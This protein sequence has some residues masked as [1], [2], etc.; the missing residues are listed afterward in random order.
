MHILASL[1]MKNRALVA[2]VTA[3]IAFFGV[4]S[5]TGLK[6]ELIPSISFPQLVV[7][8]SYPGASPDVVNDDVSTPIE[9][10]IQGVEGLD[11]TT[12]TSSTNSST[13]SATFKYGTDLGSAEQKVSQAIN[14]IKSTLPDGSDPQ[15][16]SGSIDDLPVLQ[17][18]VT[19]DDDQKA[20]AAAVDA[21][22]VPELEKIDGVR[23]ATVDGAVG[24]RVSIT[25]D[26]A[27]LATA[28]LSSSDIKT[29]L[30]QNGTLIP[31]G[32][33]TQD[34]STLS[35]QAGAKL[36]STGDIKALPL[37]GSAGSSASGSASEGAAAAAAAATAAGGT[38]A[39]VTTIGDVATVEL[40]DDPATSVSLVNGKPALTIAITKTPDGNTVAISKA[41]NDKLPDL[42]DRLGDGAKFTT[43]FDQA[44]FIQQSI[45]SLA[46]EGGLGLIFAIIVILL[47]LFSIR[48]TIVTAISIP[49]SLLIT[50]IGLQASGYTLN[51]LT[52]GA[53]TIAIGRVVDDSIVVIENIKRHLD[54]GEERAGT[55]VRAVREVAGAIT[56][57]TITTVAV[58]LPISFVGGSVG[59][60]FRPFALTVA[61][62]LLASLFVALTI[63]PV[64]AYWFLRPS[65][66]AKARLAALEA[67]QPHGNHAAAVAADAPP[68]VEHSAEHAHA[69]KSLEDDEEPTRLQRAYRPIIAWTLK[70]SVATVLLAV[71]VLVGTGALFPFMKTNFLGDSGQNSLSVTQTVPVGESLDRQRDTAL[72]A[73]SALQDVS[74]VDTV[75]V[76]V[77]SGGGLA[78]S[79]GGG[80]SNSI[81]YSITTDEDADQ[82]KVQD[83]VRD[84]FD[85][86][87]KADDVSVGAGG[88]LGGSS[89]IDV[90]ITASK[91]A[92][93]QSAD[94][95]LSAALRK[96]PEADQVESNLSA[97][98]PYVAV[99]VDRTKA[100]EAGLSE[101]AVGGL[102][103]QA[104]QPSQVGSIVI[105][106]TSLSV[107]LDTADAPTTTGELEKLQIPTASGA[108][109][110]STLAKVERVNGPAS[111]TTE[112]GLRTATVSVTPK[113]D[114][115]ASA[116]A[117]VQTAID[118]ADL[119]SG[120]TATVGGATA[121]QNDAF[122]QLGIALLVAI[123]IVYI[124][125]VATFRSL[126][127]PLLLLVSVPFAAT[128]AILL[129]VVTGV[130]LG[131]ASLIGVLML[132]GIVVTNAI[133]LVDL[134]NQYR[135]RGM[136]VRD[137]L[138]HGATRR[139][140]PILMTALAT[141]FALIPM[142]LGI[143]G[144]GG[145]ISQPLAIVVI[146]GLV[147]S[148]VLTLVVLPVIYNLVEGRRERRA[149]RKN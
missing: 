1:S 73:S 111:I 21:N 37:I 6:Q 139:L 94:D 69:A 83:D 81:S 61:I 144:H 34:G 75:Q 38:P 128:G 43:V 116:S 126:L 145:F 123:L 118:D 72:Q 52:L 88:G 86:I 102:V 24:Q 31:G 80:S 71:L 60:L 82:A 114:D 54:H 29:A 108:V 35:V 76:T 70:H 124:V 25:P 44:P 112:R 109:D 148:T 92:Q 146:G 30:E 133:V 127:Q 36:T 10:A 66:R 100:A 42:Q 58:F 17:L 97:S 105:D 23:D 137:A 122:G 56:A 95:D 132:I 49:A 48:S 26:V 57:S 53:L 149:A 51:I 90:E 2:L 19:G 131:V 117:A 101:A 140:R 27:K 41:V 142:A 110:L 129:Q 74:G 99:Q 91:Q 130:P 62:A 65:K 22:V 46:E 47:F 115:L 107:Y 18:A 68:A 103:S 135:S 28:G 64:L 104:I 77:G 15:V 59:E 12:A 8:T 125:M 55:I 136:S 106:D 85:G 89:T 16:V 13:V 50:F 20:L 96:L 119:P 98:L 45:S 79:F 9:S 33:I 143:T 84:A 14:R 67:E 40:T 7:V 138:M 121:D 32:D 11:T 134:V 78:A 39:G 63:V 141:I 113:G 87:A 5:L 120:V 93:L 3:V 147:S 4:F